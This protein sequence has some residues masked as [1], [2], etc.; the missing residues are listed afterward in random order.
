MVWDPVWEQIFSS[1]AWGRYPGEDFIRFV[2]Q[3]YYRVPDRSAV[4]I[5]E[6]GCGPGVNMWFLAREGL[7]F[8]GVDGSRSALDIASQR[9][10]QECP[11]W[12]ARGNLVLGDFAAT[13]EAQT[14]FDAVIDSE[15]VCC[16][17][18]E[19]SVAIYRRAAESLKPG[20][21]IF[22]RTFATGTWGEG[23]GE[24]LGRDCW[25]CTVGPLGNTGSV[26][27]TPREDIEELLG[28]FDLTSVDLITRTVGGTTNTIREWI[29]SGIKKT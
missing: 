27:F 11:G 15:A 4:R 3:N 8:T 22:V 26:R 12:Q 5:L 16:N 13:V 21:R 25:R 10:D 23:T 18:Y 2:A 24:K 14:G 17:S 9:L 19:E 6:L 1:R 29:V 28:A 20:G 7:G